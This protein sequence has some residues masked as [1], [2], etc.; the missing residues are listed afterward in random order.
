M[1]DKRDYYEVLGVPR[2]ASEEEIKKA[3]KKLIKK[4]HPD[5]NPD[6][7]TAEDKMKE[8]NEAYDV[9]SDADKKSRYDQFG[10][11][12]MDGNGFGGG[13]FSGFGGF[14][15]QGGFGGQGDFGDIFNM[16]FGGAGGGRGQSG[17]QRGAD[18]RVDISITFEEAAKG[19]EKDI[20]LTR[21]EHCDTCHGSGAAS[22]SSP[23]TC[24]NCGGT[25][26][27][28]VAQSTPFGQFQTVK[29]CS[30]CNGTGKIIDNPC[31]Q[32]NGT[33]KVKKT[34]IIHIKVPQGVDTGSR[35]RMQ[36]EGQAGDL[37]GLPG[38]LYIYI[39]VRPHPI[40]RRHEDDILCDYAI[41]FVQAALGDEVEVPT[42]DGKVKLT[43]PEGTQNGTTFR[44]R[45]RGF[46][47]LRGYGKGDQ[48][49][50]IVVETPTRLSSSQKDMLRQ[51]AGS[52]AD[53]GT[54]S[55]TGTGSSGGNR[56]A[57]GK[58]QEKKKGFFNKMTNND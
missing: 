57:G 32:C 34:R 23:V 12:G 28:R 51:F 38:D 2:T 40:F 43:V 42:I 1:S 45:G 46:P 58:S 14:G 17:P 9:L 33:G 49:V 54:G 13:G 30:R 7:K 56:A 27:V 41:S 53:G 24:P 36:S 18:L 16:F 22:G 55:G 29:T 39:T 21:L 52:F 5:L 19:A 48:H 26:K 50:R 8:I 20:E 4:Y 10:H 35:L 3:Y 37:G 15:S 31:K 47:R 44:L 11:A 25:G 6:S